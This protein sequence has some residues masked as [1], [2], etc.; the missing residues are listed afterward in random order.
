MTKRAHAERLANAAT[1]TLARYRRGL[2]TRATCL[3]H[4]HAILGQAIDHGCERQLTRR[5]KGSRP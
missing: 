5:L 4:L 1:R 2:I 3:T